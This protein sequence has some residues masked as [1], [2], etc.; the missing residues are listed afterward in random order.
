[1]VTRTRSSKVSVQV[2]ILM[3][4][5]WIKY[6][7]CTF[8]FSHLPKPPQEHIRCHS[9]PAHLSSCFYFEHETASECIL[10]I[11]VSLSRLGGGTSVGRWEHGISQRHRAA[12]ERGWGQLELSEMG[13]VVSASVNTPTLWKNMQKMSCILPC[14]DTQTWSPWKPEACS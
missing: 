13:R 4:H 9:L 12:T 14:V 5:F 3:F 10:L 11:A 7:S 1:M 8:F 6:C 2:C